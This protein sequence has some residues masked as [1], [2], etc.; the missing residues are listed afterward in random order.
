M[1]NQEVGRRTFMKGV[2][3]SAAV[4]SAG[5]YGFSLDSPAVQVVR[6]QVSPSG[7]TSQAP[8]YSIKFAVIGMNHPHIYSMVPAVIRGGG[9][10][11]ALYAKEQELVAAFT[12]KF[13]QAKLARK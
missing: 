5:P 3:G 12:E 4:V 1:K 7:E 13:P 9:E 6:D 10:L 8:Q 2:L 11:V